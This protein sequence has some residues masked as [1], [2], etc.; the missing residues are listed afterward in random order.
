ME[1]LMEYVRTLIGQM[2]EWLKGEDA[3]EI[4][5]RALVVCVKLAQE[6]L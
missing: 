5:R 6:S 2:V 4:A 3:F 1:T